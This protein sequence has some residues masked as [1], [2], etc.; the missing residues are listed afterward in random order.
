MN[1]ESYRC[2]KF[3]GIKM[4]IT[5]A[6]VTKVVKN[7]IEGNKIVLGRDVTF[8]KLESGTI[9]GVVFAS[10]CPQDWKNEAQELGKKSKIE[11]YD[12]NGNGLDL[13]ALCKKPFAVTVAGIV[14]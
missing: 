13:G 8:K 5:K 11:F 2:I 12:Y 14:K 9:T 3:M 1:D 7:A 6:S 10:N 4:S